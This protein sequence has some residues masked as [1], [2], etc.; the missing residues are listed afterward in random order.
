MARLV[1]EELAADGEPTVPRAAEHI[2][3]SPASDR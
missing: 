2:I 1:R 3:L